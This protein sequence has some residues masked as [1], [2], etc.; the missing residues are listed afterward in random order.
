MATGDQIPEEHHIAR[1]C[2][3]HTLDNGK[4]TSASFELREGES[5]LSVNWIE[6]IDPSDSSRAIG[7]LWEHYS[8]IFRG[9]K[10]KSRIALLNV[11]NT[12]EHVEQESTDK[13][14]LR[15]NHNP[16]PPNNLSHAGIYGY[17]FMDTLIA[18]TIAQ[19]VAQENLFSI[20]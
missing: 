11:G 2:K 6:C 19:S 8:N 12:L 10:P 1:Y 20:P 16:T 14:K 13:R 9:I 15:I 4:P 5:Y 18:E 7:E 3:R 17:S